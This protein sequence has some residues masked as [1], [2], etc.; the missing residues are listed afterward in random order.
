[1]HSLSMTQAWVTI[2]KTE[3]W[4]FTQTHGFDEASSLP[5]IN[6]EV[7]AGTRTVKGLDLSKGPKFQ[8]HIISCWRLEEYK[9]KNFEGRIGSGAV[10]PW[11]HPCPTIGPAHVQS[12][13]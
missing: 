6:S 9:K 2:W 11:W 7:E 10:A 12:P 1:M 5:W 3:Q 8:P 4:R 13:D